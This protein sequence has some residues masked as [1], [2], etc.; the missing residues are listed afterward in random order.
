MGGDKPESVV[1]RQEQP[2][3]SRLLQDHNSVIDNLGRKITG[4]QAG[5]AKDLVT[6]AKDDMGSD[7]AVPG[8]KVEDLEVKFD[9][10]VEHSNLAP[11]DQLALEAM[12]R[13]LFLTNAAGLQLS[14]D[15][16]QSLDAPNNHATSERL[17][18]EFRKDV[19]ALASGASQELAPHILVA[20]KDVVPDV[21]NSDVVIALPHSRVPSANG[22]IVVAGDGD[23]GVNVG[24]GGTLIIGGD[25]TR[26]S[27]DEGATELPPGTHVYRKGREVENGK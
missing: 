23:V 13:E 15:K 17:F 26:L 6:I 16:V 19:T 21:D 12:G 24:G 14:M 10:K 25:D 9:K 1:Q 4:P 7:G 18:E 2:T 22:V 20:Q 8:G 11:I 27:T 3:S 5:V